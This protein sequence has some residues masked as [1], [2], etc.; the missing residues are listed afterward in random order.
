MKLK[1]PVPKTNKDHPKTC[2]FTEVFSGSVIV[3]VNVTWLILPTG[4][5]LVDQ[6]SLLL[7]RQN[8]HGRSIFLRVMVR[9]KV[10]R[11]YNTSCGKKLWLLM[12]TAPMSP[13]KASEFNLFKWE[14]FKHFTRSYQ[15]PIQVERWNLI[16]CLYLQCKMLIETISGT[17]MH[18]ES[19][20]F[21]LCTAAEVL[22]NPPEDLPNKLLAS[23]LISGFDSPSKTLC[24]FRVLRQRIGTRAAMACENRTSPENK[25]LV[26]YLPLHQEQ[27]FL[28]GASGWSKPFGCC[29][30]Q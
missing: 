25:I 9:E 6:K 28:V 13:W 30:L 10:R 7:W 5:L 18:T 26:I 16:K 22:T 8:F 23:W 11:T 24:R 15:L 2:S 29:H 20:D 17:Q 27:I 3:R 21:I 14:K 19:A 12:E 4:R 1:E